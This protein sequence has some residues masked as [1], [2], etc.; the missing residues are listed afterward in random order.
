M[1]TGHEE[2]T[3]QHREPHLERQA[4]VVALA[5]QGG[6]LNALKIEVIAQREAAD[7]ERDTQTTEHLED[8]AAMSAWLLP[9]K[10]SGL[11]DLADQ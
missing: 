7:V 5:G 1:I 3:A 4:Q 11:A 2:A 9:K 8:V 10:Y 6:E